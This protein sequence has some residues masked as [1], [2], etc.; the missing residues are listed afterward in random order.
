[1]SADWTAL[2]I[3]VDR[4]FYVYDLV[5]P[6]NGKT[7]YVGKGTGDRAKHHLRDSLAG[8]QSNEAKHKVIMSIVDL[9]EVPIEVI[10]ARFEDEDSAIKFEAERIAEIGIDN[11]TNIKS[12]GSRSVDILRDV[13]ETA[14]RIESC[15]K[16]DIES[17]NN[18]RVIDFQMGFIEI[19][20]MLTEKANA[21][22][23]HLCR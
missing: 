17:S 11:L 23:L 8:R 21:M 10:V 20:R 9:G 6:R 15:A 22:R 13:L 19:S 3:E 7:F 2:K 5:D 14:E 18:R 16:V 1:M 12:S 4:L